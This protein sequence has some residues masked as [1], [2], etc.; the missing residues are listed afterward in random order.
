LK[1]ITLALK[2]TSEQ[3]ITSNCNTRPKNVKNKF[4]KKNPENA[5]NGKIENIAGSV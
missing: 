1:K 3:P 5:Q 2:Q 4:R